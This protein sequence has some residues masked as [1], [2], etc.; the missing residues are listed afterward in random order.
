MIRTDL[1]IMRTMNGPPQDWLSHEAPSREAPPPATTAPDVLPSIN[2]ETP[3]PPA[4][5]AFQPPRLRFSLIHLLSVMTVMTVLLGVARW[6]VRMLPF[7]QVASV[8]AGVAV[9]YRTGALASALVGAAVF[10]VGLGAVVF[11]GLMPHFKPVEAAGLAFVMVAPAT[12]GVGAAI[13][14]FFGTYNDRRRRSERRGER[15]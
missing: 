8:L 12:L 9:Y 13:G 11:F 15:G 10:Y 1:L 7:L 5:D 6:E 2:V 3:L 4:K 14:Y